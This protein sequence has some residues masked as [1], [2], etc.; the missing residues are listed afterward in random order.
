MSNRVIDV[1]MLARVE[2]EGALY[3]SL[4]DGVPKQ[5]ELRIFEPPRLFESI[6]RGRSC[7]EVPDITARICGICPVAYQM[8]SCAAI[9][10][11]LGV[12]VDEPV[13]SLR[14]LLYDGEWIE[15][16]A[17]HIFMLHLPDFLGYDD[18]IAMAKAHGPLVRDAL[19]IK[20]AG[21][22]I[23]RVLGGRSVH[24][25]NARIGGFHRF[26]TKAELDALLPELSAAR[27]KMMAAI[28]VLSQLRFASSASEPEEV[29][30]THPTEYLTIEGR[31][32][33]SAGVD[34]SVDEYESVFEEQHVERSNALRS[35][36]RGG[37]IY[38]TGPLARYALARDR[39]TPLAKEAAAKA[40][41]GAREPNPFRSLLVRAVET[42]HALDQAI[43]LITSYDAK[44]GQ[45]PKLVDPRGSGVRIGCG[46]SEA[47]R[48]L[49]WHRYE[50][51]RDGKIQ[52][53]KIVPPTS[54][55]QLA[56]EEDLWSVA[57]QLSEL[58]EEEARRLA[59]ST[60]RS[61]DPCIS[62][63]THFLKLHFTAAPSES[64]V[65]VQGLS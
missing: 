40:G 65:R 12:R 10:S 42:V 4:E 52:K 54:Q 64:D 45:E 41:L 27:D 57:R 61:Y 58:P 15:S 7:L 16:H 48:G 56:I 51:D 30:L 62:C 6:L 19:A 18:V 50:I 2:G 33:S 23:L 26:P 22:A 24:P 21:N 9:E 29:A 32:C 1:S 37:G 39:L 3:I 43:G 34:V 44:P 25:I 20:K 13:L 59:E 17:L 31:V 60:I 36:K 38:R 47:P 14:K 8:S 55:N 63:A 53:A 35:R 46:A 5:V 28:E 49:L 11:A